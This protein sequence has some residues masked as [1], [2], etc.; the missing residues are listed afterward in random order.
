MPGQAPAALDVRSSE[1][2]ENQGTAACSVQLLL[3]VAMP[4]APSSVLATSPVAWYLLFQQL[5]TY[6]QRTEAVHSLFRLTLAGHV[7]TEPGQA[8]VKL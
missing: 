5:S 3:L 6:S 2:G 8:F 7:Q 4:G 1:A